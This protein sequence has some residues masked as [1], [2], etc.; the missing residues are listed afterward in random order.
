M[1]S[2]RMLISY[3][4]RWEELPHGSQR[5][6]GA[7]NKEILVQK[8][9]TYEELLRVFQS[10]VKL[11]QNKYVIEIQSIAVVPGSTWPTVISDDD[12][13]QFI[14][15]E[16]KAIPQEHQTFEEPIHEEPT[17]GSALPQD[18]RGT[19]AD[20]KTMNTKNVNDMIE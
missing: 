15:Q 4:E 16:D 17:R 7:V 3:N 20:T 8:N 10:I 6:V 1:D 18:M 19:P 12:D 14:L 13:V 11:D 5:Y 9:L 2:V